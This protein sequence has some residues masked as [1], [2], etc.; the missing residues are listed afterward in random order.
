[1]PVVCIGLPRHQALALQ[2]V[3]E[4]DHRGAVN[5]ET[6]GGLLVGLGL[7]TVQGQQDGQFAGVHA[8]G[9]R[10]DLN[11]PTSLR[12]LGC[13]PTVPTIQQAAADGIL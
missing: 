5:P 4:S 6:S 7:T 12:E 1:M 13:R 10:G 3:Q 9:V 8:T 11:D 2:P